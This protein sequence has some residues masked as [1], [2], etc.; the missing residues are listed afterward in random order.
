MRSLWVREGGLGGLTVIIV[1]L[2]A[3]RLLMPDWDTS[4][5]CQRTVLKYDC[6]GI[7]L[8]EL[9][10]CNRP[11]QTLNM[12]LHVFFMLY[13]QVHSRV[14][15]VLGKVALLHFTPS[16]QPDATWNQPLFPLFRRRKLAQ[17]WG[18]GNSHRPQ[19][20]GVTYTNK[21]NFSFLIFIKWRL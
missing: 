4:P 18:F 11:L 17:G 19:Q 13:F 9:S 21:L 15:K 20:G 2:L 10:S 5:L 16:K 7:N 1:L 6:R 12:D 3:V 8:W 14:F